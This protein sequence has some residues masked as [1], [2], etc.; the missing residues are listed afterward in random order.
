[1]EEICAAAH[2]LGRTNTGTDGLALWNGFKANLEDAETEVGTWT[3][4]TDAERLVLDDADS[5]ANDHPR[6]LE[7]HYRSQPHRIRDRKPP[8]KARLAQ[9]Y[10]NLGS[11]G[12][13]LEPLEKFIALER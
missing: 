12:A 4:L 1:M 10:F 11:A 9:V 8:T 5:L 2:S 7:A 6:W 13:P 3:D